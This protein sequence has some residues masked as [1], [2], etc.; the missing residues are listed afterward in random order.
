MTSSIRGLLGKGVD[1]GVDVGV[2]VGVLGVDSVEA[3]SSTEDSHWSGKTGIH[4]E[5]LHIFGRTWIANSH[6][7]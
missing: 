5:A 7:K 6:K 2:E 4:V 3:E 1:A